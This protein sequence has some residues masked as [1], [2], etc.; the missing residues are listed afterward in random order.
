MKLNFQIYNE[1]FFIQLNSLEQ[2]FSKLKNYLIIIRKT[3]SEKLIKSKE[4]IGLIELFQ[5]YCPYI[6]NEIKSEILE[7]DQKNTLVELI[8]F[9]NSKIRVPNFE[10]YDIN[11]YYQ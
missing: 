9:Y 8:E 4:R 3:N 10:F 7:F 5:L 1:R 11:I 6:T 2:K